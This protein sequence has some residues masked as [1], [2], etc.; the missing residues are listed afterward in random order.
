MLK[1]QDDEML[2]L[3]GPIQRK[4]LHQ[5]LVLRL[6]GA[7]IIGLGAGVLL[8]LFARFLPIFYYKWAAVS[9]PVLGLLSGLIWTLRKKPTLVAA[10]KEADRHGLAER[11]VTALENRAQTSMLAVRQRED[12]LS[13][14]RGVLPQVLSGIAVFRFSRIKWI[15]LSA[16]LASW[17][18]LFYLPNGMDQVIAQKLQ[19][20]AQLAEA[21]KQLDELAKSLANEKSLSTEQKKKAAD[22]MDEAKRKL[23]SANDTADRLNALRAAEKQLEKWKQAQGGQARAAAAACA[24]HERRARNEVG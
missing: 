18:T 14:L 15:G 20:Q 2:T 10:A 8:L 16:V 24:R 11:T 12:A 1:R 7:A 3:L 17:L 5:K 22:I 6:A 21:K 4:L 9:F 13:R 23:A 19:E